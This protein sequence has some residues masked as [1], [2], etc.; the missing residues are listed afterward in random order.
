[1]SDIMS[2]CGYDVYAAFAFVLLVASQATAQD[3]GPYQFREPE[4]FW[5][6]KVVF[7]KRG[8]VIEDDDFIVRK[9]YWVLD[10]SVT[11][12]VVSVEPAD[13]K[14][15]FLTVRF[16]GMGGGWRQRG[17]NVRDRTV[18]RTRRDVTV[19]SDPYGDGA[20]V[21][22][23]EV[24]FSYRIEGEQVDPNRCGVIVGREGPVTMV[25]FPNHIVSLVSPRKGDTVVRSWDWHDGFA[26]GGRSARGRFETSFGECVGTVLCDRDEHGFIEVEW[27]KTKRKKS[28]RF[29]HFGYFDIEPA[30]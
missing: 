19:R 7:Q 12:Q 23:D 27:Q 17:I 18:S 6:D 28:H 24:T 26:D 9:R 14:D 11:G 10:Q 8:I 30:L 2:R 3:D 15:V 20:N 5:K 22:V 16:D 29:D 13:K 21:N 4:K 25:R 1:M